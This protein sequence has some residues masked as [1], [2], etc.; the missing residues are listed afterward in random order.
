MRKGALLE[1]IKFGL[2]GDARQA[3]CSRGRQPQPTGKSQVLRK[4]V[5]QILLWSEQQRGGL[6]ST[7]VISGGKC[8]FYCLIL[9]TR[10]KVIILK[11]LKL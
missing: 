5:S 10:L 3:T 1:L 4:A 8:L 9:F 2:R 7:G 11:N 6:R